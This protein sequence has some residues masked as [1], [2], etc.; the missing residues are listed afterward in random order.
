MPSSGLGMHTQIN[1]QKMSGDTG[2]H[3]RT[4]GECPLQAGQAAAGP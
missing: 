2:T 4:W 1:G 3:S